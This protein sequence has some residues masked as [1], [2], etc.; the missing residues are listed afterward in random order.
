METLARIVISTAE[1]CRAAGV[2]LITG[3]VCRAASFLFRRPLEI[4]A[5]S[6]DN[7]MQDKCNCH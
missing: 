4:S 2:Q 3:D 6:Q 5:E 7:H 1:A